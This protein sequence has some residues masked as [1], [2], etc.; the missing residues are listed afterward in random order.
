VLTGDL[1][2]PRLRKRGSRLEVEM[3]PVTNRHWLKTAA[4]LINLFA[5][6]EGQS[7]ETW[8]AALEAYVTVQNLL[9]VLSQVFPDGCKDLCPPIW[10][11]FPRKFGKKTGQRLLQ[12]TFPR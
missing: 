12:S 8:D 9:P 10:D 3:L 11:I 6:H 2:R 1:V 4:D 5:E 7:R